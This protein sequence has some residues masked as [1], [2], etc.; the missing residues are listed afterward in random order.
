MTQTLLNDMHWNGIH[1]HCTQAPQGSREARNSVANT[2]AARCPVANTVAPVHGHDF[3][4]P[5]WF[6]ECG[7][8]ELA[9]D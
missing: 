9:D 6:A 7:C 2:R 1:T 5:L 8:S 3:D 4:G